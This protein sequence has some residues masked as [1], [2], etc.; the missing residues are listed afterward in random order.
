MKHF[1]I[2]LREKM[3]GFKLSKENF[4]IGSRA[5]SFEKGNYLSDE[6]CLKKINNGKYNYDLNMSFYKNL[7]KEDFNK[8]IDKFVTQNMFNEVFNLSLFMNKK[9]Y[10]LMV[11][12][13]YTQVYIGTS[14]DLKKR[15]TRHWSTTLPLDRV[16]L[17]TPETSKIS[18]DSFRALDTTR[19]FIK[20]SDEVFLNENSYIDQ[21]SDKFICN[22][23]AGGNNDTDKIFRTLKLRKLK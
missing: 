18:I 5:D 21:F 3:D 20:E 1:N 4:T 22:R 23:T 19:I 8:E 2:N 10:Y 9:G 15:I 11:L 13:E 14:K 7:N 17:W 16:V 12:D 6:D